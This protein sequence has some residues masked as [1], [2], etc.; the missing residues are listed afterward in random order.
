[1]FKRGIIIS[2]TMQKGY[3]LSNIYFGKVELSDGDTDLSGLFEFRGN[4]YYFKLEYY[5]QEVHR[6]ARLYDSAGRMVPVDAD[7]FSEISQA[8]DVLCDIEAD[9]NNAF[10]VVKAAA[11]FSE[12][13]D[14]E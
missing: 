4:Y 9:V 1:M 7:Q 13:V 2:L 14:G 6:F 12:A 11:S 3:I 10:N 8:F 5:P